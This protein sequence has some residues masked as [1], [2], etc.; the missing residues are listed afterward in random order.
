MLEV[1]GGV[2]RDPDDVP[3]VAVTLL[4]QELGPSCP[5]LV[6][7]SFTEEYLEVSVVGEV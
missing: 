7:Y 3:W 2:F 4:V 6:A 5:L 1:A